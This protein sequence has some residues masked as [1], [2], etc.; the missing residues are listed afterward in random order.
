MCMRLIGSK[1]GGF[2]EE[3]EIEG[4]EI[5][6]I[7]RYS[8]A[9][10]SHLRGLVKEKMDTSESFESDRDFDEGLVAHGNV[11]LTALR[12]L[13]HTREWRLLP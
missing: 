8:D 3:G 2:E 5:Y 7:F 13:F 11:L 1:F 10:N 4:V 9:T 12:L 6:S